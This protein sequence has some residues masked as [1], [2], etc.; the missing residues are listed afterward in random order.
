MRKSTGFALLSIFLIALF[1][2]FLPL[3]RHLFWG[4]DFGEYYFLTRDLVSNGHLALPYYG[5]GFTYPY[6]PGMFILGGILGSTSASISVSTA[7]IP[8]FLA[9]FTVFPIFLMGRELYHEDAPGL[10]AA[11]IS[12][13]ALP[14]VYVTSH[15][16]PGSIGELLFIFCI[17]LFWK[18]HTKPKTY[19]LLY[20]ASLALV[21]THH[22]SAYFLIIVLV[23]A[24]FLR[25]FVSK[26]SDVEKLRRSVVFVTFLVF[27]NFLYWIAYAT[28]FRDVIL[29]KVYLSWWGVILA[30]VLLMVVLFAIIKL[31]RR[32]DWG[33]RPEYPR[34]KDRL[35]LMVVSFIGIYV[36]MAIII[37]VAIPGTTVALDASA[38]IF[39]TPLM[40][41]IAVAMAGR[42]FSDFARKGYDLTSW[43][44]AILGSLVLGT[45][46]ASDVIVPYRHMQYMIAPMALVAGFGI[47]R[48]SGL[49]GVTKKKGKVM[50]GALVIA[51]LVALASTSYPPRK[52]LAGHQEGIEAELVSCAQFSGL[53]ADGLIVSDHRASTIIFG[54][55][56]RNA[57]W[58][59]APDSLL[60]D[61]FEDAVTEMREVNSPSGKKRVDYAVLD[62]DME[63]GAMIYPWDPAH[64]MSTEAIE[65]FDKSPY[66]KLYDNG[67]SRLYYVNWGLVQTG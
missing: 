5:W 46:F 65:K 2:R 33:Y 62:K 61:T 44:I 18:A 17:F 41:P 12:A 22:L 42:R 30:F 37:L 14:A 66:M 63:I 35:S 64:V 9:A 60:A 23:T 8:A 34:L 10:I 21:I 59:T 27:M 29:S 7:L 26:K 52:I 32:I 1:L 43:F 47:T 58:D 25:E 28:P 50:V 31:R 55:G 13:V 19:Y 4:A 11:G 53:Y 57:T 40:I 39:F 45:L 3:T 16:M 24:I 49:F 56:E 54:F 36:I 48:M 6:F 15:A 20:P 38:A 51:L 67:Y